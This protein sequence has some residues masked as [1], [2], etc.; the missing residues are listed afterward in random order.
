[1]SALPWTKF[2]WDHWENDPGLALCSL[3]AQGLWM[4]LLCLAQKE[5]GY[6]LLKG[7]APTVEKL[8]KLVR[9]TPETVDELLA[10]LE[11]EGV[12]SRRADGV[13]YSRRIVKDLRSAR[14]NQKNGKLGGNPSLRKDKGNSE[15]VNPIANPRLK[16]EK[17][18]EEKKEKE[19]PLPPTL[20]TDVESVW[21]MIP[22]ASKS[23]ST[24]YDIELALAAAIGR[25][26]TAADVLGGLA[27]Y[28]A[29]DAGDDD[30]KFAKAAHRMIEGDRWKDFA[31]Q[32]PAPVTDD[33]WAKRLDYFSRK[34]LWSEKWG[35]AIGE[36]GCR[37]PPHILGAAA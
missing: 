23:R 34:G 24:R 14:T 35:P 32:A 13:I 15:P 17:R 25:G 6:L 20:K 19:S 10:E 37:V 36:P 31:P 8:A 27:A 9:S 4:R 12:F 18:R 28:Y 22:K 16:A 7:E 30:G 11:S 21:A 33:D 3:A 29:T 26:H 2:S 1:M 5:G